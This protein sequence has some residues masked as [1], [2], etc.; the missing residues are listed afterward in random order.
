MIS[1]RISSANQFQP[2]TTVTTNASQDW[3]VLMLAICLAVYCSPRTAPQSS[4]EM[5]QLA[6]VFVC[7]YDELSPG[8]VI[9]YLSRTC[10]ATSCSGRLTVWLR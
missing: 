3:Q 6:E 1:E 5:W 4:I 7:I 2:H 9:G 10:T 8:Q